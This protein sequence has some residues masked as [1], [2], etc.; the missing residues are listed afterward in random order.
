MLEAEFQGNP[1]DTHLCIIISPS[2]DGIYEYDII[3]VIITIY[4]KRNFSNVVNVPI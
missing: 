1:N 3:S 2:V 4:G